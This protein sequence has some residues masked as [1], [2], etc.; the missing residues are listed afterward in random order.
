MIQSPHFD[1]KIPKWHHV[2]CFF[3]HSAA[4]L[5][6]PSQMSHFDALRNDDRNMIKVMIATISGQA[7][8]TVSGGSSK[9]DVEGVFAFGSFT[10][11][12]AK[13][14]R[15]NCKECQRSIEKDDL[16]IGKVEKS[17]SFGGMVPRWMH[18]DCF[19]KIGNRGCTSTDLISGYDA[20]T[21][22]DM[23]RIKKQ[24]GGDSKKRSAT[25]VS[26]T[27]KSKKKQK[28][29]ETD[30]ALPAKSEAE[31]AFEQQNDVLWSIKDELRTL[32]KEWLTSMLY[33]NNQT[34]TKT[35]VKMIDR[36]A[37]GILFGAMPKCP[38]CPDG[39]LFVHGPLVKC[40]GHASE[41][42][43]CQYQIPLTELVTVSW[44]FPEGF[45]ADY[46]FFKKFA[47]RKRSRVAQPHAILAS[48][49]AAAVESEK[50]N[51]SPDGLFA[52]FCI[53]VV[54]PLVSA[55]EFT[56]KV[57][58]NG[59]KVTTTFKKTV[60]LV[61]ATKDDMKDESRKIKK[62]A[63]L[64]VPV[65]M[66]QFID[67]SIAKGTLLDM[68]H[69]R[70]DLTPALPAAV[71]PT[72][73]TQSTKKKLKLKEGCH[74]PVDPLSELEETHHVLEEGRTIYDAML[75]Q[76][77]AS[78][79]HNGYYGLQVLEHDRK[80]GW[81]VFR[82]WGRVGTQIGSSKIENFSDK[83]SA[84]RE[85]KKL[86]Y[87][88]TG[89]HFGSDYKKVTG[90]FFPIALDYGQ[91]GADE[92]PSGGIEKSS[93]LDPRVQSVISTI[94]D[95]SAM[96]ATLRELEIDLDKMP[97]G[98]MTKGHIR[99]GFDV[100]NQFQDIFTGK[101]VPKNMKVMLLELTNKFY[102]IIPHNHGTGPIRIIDSMVILD[103][104]IKLLEALIEIE[105]ATSLLKSASSGE[106]SKL[107]K[108][109]A[110]LKCD[111]KPLPVDSKEME[112]IKTY[113]KNTHAA[114]HKQ[115]SLEVLDAFEVEKEG[116][117]DR[118]AAWKDNENRMLLWHGSRLTNWVG[119]LSQGLR[120]APP[121][122]PVT[123]YMF[124]KGVYFADMVS[125]SANYCFTNPS[126][127]VGFLLLC[128]VALGTTHD[129]FEAD[130]NASQLPP[131]TH[132]TRGVGLTCPDPNQSV[133]LEDGVQVPL[134]RGV[135]AQKQARSLLYNEFIVYDVSQIRLRYLVKT[136]FNYK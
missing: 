79:D 100:L 87:E 26:S 98:Q 90:K 25:D 107:D 105:V 64:K 108:N 61:V 94:F 33:L 13:S 112:I 130:Y 84:K 77:D 20:L 136:K 32:S 125:K 91:I 117:R 4:G 36:C 128:E 68:N 85:F 123:G 24:I 78:S 44:K 121:E 114:T 83:E 57:K 54:T 50:K 52:D 22:K 126:N 75:N 97:L 72:K 11:E 15:S 111:L 67:D 131:G 56:T 122:A 41:W 34:V 43:R 119:I 132:S 89:N 58:A 62:A 2:K 92:V 76:A 93:T 129:L 59:G 46:K 42:A 63:K 16:R 21:I 109:Y 101:T 80:R 82:K 95:I 66:E 1:G 27:S 51:E 10:A 40:H 14:S 60:N 99:S 30:S 37:E 5:T 6:D 96:E 12:Y 103:E 39:D 74:A 73:S 106:E 70:I 29:V 104:K 53:T 127:N 17:E 102:T 115:Y 19:F 55:D 134:G 45:L 47:D 88:K 49:V 69:Y 38:D 86:F 113:V 124:G 18:F 81:V 8:T 71:T 118:F 9:I 110:K 35:D 116:D 120:I 28:T 48:T 3:A 133:I 23:G 65:V 7:S 31:I 135:P